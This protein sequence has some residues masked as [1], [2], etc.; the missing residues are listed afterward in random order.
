MGKRKRSK[1]QVIT[2]FPQNVEKPIFVLNSI[3]NVTVLFAISLPYVIGL[4]S[5]IDFITLAGIG[6]ISYDIIFGVG[7][8]KLVSSCYSKRL[9]RLDNKKLKEFIQLDCNAKSDVINALGIEIDEL[10]EA[11]TTE[12][13]EKTRSELNDKIIR[14][15]NQIQ[16]FSREFEK[17]KGEMSSIIE[18]L[19]KPMLNDLDNALKVLEKVKSYSGKCPSEFLSDYENIIKICG[20]FLEKAKE[21]PFAMNRLGKT[22]NVYLNE[23]LSLLDSYNELKNDEDDKY[24]KDTIKEILDE[25]VNHL[26]AVGKEVYENSKFQ[27]EIS[28]S[29]LKDALKKEGEK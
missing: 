24:Y 28:A 23:L 2:R 10:K 4:I 7:A 20:D 15:N 3:L 16:V 21:N 29:T 17:Q 22:F 27:F 11:Y 13:N 8:N 6:Y 26:C 19:E 1:N 25:I 9:L 14:L 18:T 12:P 5:I